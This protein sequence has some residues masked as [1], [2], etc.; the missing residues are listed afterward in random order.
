VLAVPAFFTDRH[1]KAI[2][3]AAHSAG[4][5]PIASV[6]TVVAGAV[7]YSHLHPPAEGTPAKKFLFVD[8]GHNTTSAAVV[9]IAPGRMEVLSQEADGKVGSRD[10]DVALAEKFRAHFIEKHKVDPLGGSANS[11]AKVTARLLQAAE[12]AKQTLSTIPETDVDVPS[13][14]NDLDMHM[15]VS[16]TLLYEWSRPVFDRLTSIIE[17]ALAKASVTAE[18]IDICEVVGGGARVP[19]VA[20]VLNKLLKNKELP[21]HSDGTAPVPEGAA[22][23]AATEKGEP[24]TIAGVTPLEPVHD[25]EE[26]KQIAHREAQSEEQD[27]QNEQRNSEKNQ[28]ESLIYKHREQVQALKELTADEKKLLLPV[29][30]EAEEWLGNTDE[31]TSIDQFKERREKLLATLSG[32][33]KT[34]AAHLAQLEERRKQE[35]LEAIEAEA[36]RN[37]QPRKS[38][39]DKP[40]TNTEK[41][42]SAQKD[43]YQGNVCF[44]EVDYLSAA[45]KYISALTQFDQMHDVS[46]PQQKEVNDVKLSCYLNLSA[47][48]LKLGKQEKAIANAS[49]AL[50]IDPKSAK[51][52]FRRAQA[53]I[54]LKKWEDAKTDLVSA[55]QFDPTSADVK[56]ALANVQKELDAQVARE[57]Q[58][59]SNMFG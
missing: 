28:L 18:N 34:Y 3:S 36:E 19:E 49:S 27:R 57:K 24:I 46:E 6:S 31:E 50:E 29:L 41:I 15:R 12:K 43:K 45:G 5:C 11:K 48:Y 4:L 13:L 16:R 14:F 38:R 26:L 9:E 44:K 40:K 2:V 22:L 51:A 54:T 58:L 55:T 8:V 53:K 35:H 39:T 25:E 20:V 32:S 42:E 1:I 21:R 56:A 37:K 30:N 17:S 23:V 33:S 10:L 7:C 52:L 47:C 59:Y